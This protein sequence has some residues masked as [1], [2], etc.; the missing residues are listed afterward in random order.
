[1]N[2][3]TESLEHFFFHWMISCPQILNALSSEHAFTHTL[4][5]S[6]AGLDHLHF[7][8]SLKSDVNPANS[9]SCIITDTLM[10]SA[11][12]LFPDSPA[13]SGLKLKCIEV[14]LLGSLDEVS[15]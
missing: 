5:W 4:K 2:R 8:C 1:M 10:L 3:C 7:N 6:K 12:V 13:F 11:K 9:L 14:I 15:I